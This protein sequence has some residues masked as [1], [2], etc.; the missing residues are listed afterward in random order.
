MRIDRKPVTHE[1][2]KKLQ[3]IATQRQCPHCHRKMAVHLG[4]CRFCQVQVA[5]PVDFLNMNLRGK[6]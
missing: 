6:A 2:C 3:S 5:Q 4:R 1:H